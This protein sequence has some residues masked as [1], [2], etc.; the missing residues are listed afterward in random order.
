[1]TMKLQLRSY[2][3][4]VALL[5]PVLGCQAGTGAPPAM[6]ETAAASA[7]PPGGHLLKNSDFNDGESL[8][9]M[10]SFTNPATGEAMVDNGPLCIDIQNKGANPWDAQVR[11]REMVI[12]KGHTYNVSLKAWADKPT[13]VRP[14]VG[15]AGPPYAEY[16]AGTLDLTTTPQTFQ[17]SFTMA[18]EDDPTAELALHMGGNLASADSFKVC[19][20]DI[21]WTDPEFT[22]TEAA[23][24]PPPPNVRVNQVGYYPGLAKHAVAVNAATAPL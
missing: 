2:C 15:M 21:Y 20:D 3:S 1:F 8:P 19:S 16:W 18:G 7:A 4:C 6:P 9:W 12:Q 14:K 24:E 23:S 11:H 5:V 17:G 10:P 22:P 13:R